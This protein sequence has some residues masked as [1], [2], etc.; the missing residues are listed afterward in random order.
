MGRNH[1]AKCAAGGVVA[2]L[3][4]LRLYQT[5]HDI[6]QHAG[7]E[8]LSCAGFFLVGVFLQKP[9]IQI[10]KPLL[11][12][13]KPV[14]S[15]DGGDNFFQVLRFVNVGGRALIDF[16]HAACAALAQVVQ[17]LLV[18]F[19]QFNSAFGGQA[20]PAVGFRY[21]TLCARLLRHLQKQDIGQLRHILMIGDAVVTE[22]VAEVPE[23]G[24]NF[25]CCHN[26]I[27]PPSSYRYSFSSHTRLSSLFP[28]TLLIFTKP[29]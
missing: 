23:F 4:G 15:V 9:L 13:G 11:A 21:L 6:N 5:G 20:V 7:R 18:E 29:P 16:P 8:I 26:A 24:N 22:N 12:G 14:Q 19:F 25:L 10:A 27:F 28:N 1:K 17:Q 3:A 2:S